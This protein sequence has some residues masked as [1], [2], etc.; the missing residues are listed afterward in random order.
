MEKCANPSKIHMLVENELDAAAAERLRE[1]IDSCEQCSDH[2]E[3]FVRIKGLIEGTLAANSGYRDTSEEIISRTTDPEPGRV[4][5]KRIKRFLKL[6]AT[7]MAASL[8]II[9]LA[10][11]L[12]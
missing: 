9:L 6:A 12:F 2:F 11:Y 1:H 10:G 4:F 8:G 5:G 7:G 3:R